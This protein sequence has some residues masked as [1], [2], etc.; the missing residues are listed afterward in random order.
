MRPRFKQALIDANVEG[1]ILLH[2]RIGVDGKIREVEVVSPL[3]PDLEVE[4]IAAV[5][6]WELSPTLLNCEPI[7]VRMY[8][9]VSF[10]LNR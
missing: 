6:Q 5:S 10:K 7:E 8:V 1:E 4:T 3:H 9:S 2:V